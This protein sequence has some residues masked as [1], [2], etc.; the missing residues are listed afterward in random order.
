MN[1]DRA[2]QPRRGAYR[3]VRGEPNVAVDRLHWALLWAFDLKLGGAREGLRVERDVTRDFARCTEVSESNVRFRT[4]DGC[5]L[6]TATRR[7]SRRFSSTRRDLV[8]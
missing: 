4:V 8:E 2:D 7:L 3:R 6:A 1:V 5:S